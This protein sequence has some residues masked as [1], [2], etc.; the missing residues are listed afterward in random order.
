[1]VALARNHVSDVGPFC[2]GAPPSTRSD[3]PPITLNN[4]VFRKHHPLNI[5]T[6]E[7]LQ[8]VPQLLRHLSASTTGALTP[9]D[10]EGSVEYKWRLTNI[11]ATRLEHLKTQMSFRVSEGN[12]QCFYEIGVAD[13]GVQRGLE[14]GD[15]EA[16][17][18]TVQQMAKSLELECQ[19]VCERV[20]SLPGQPRL[21]CAEI[22]VSRPSLSQP[23]LRIAFCGSSDSGKSTLVSVLVNGSLDDGTGTM[24]QSVF[25]HKHEMT[26]GQ[27]SS[28][29]RRVLGFDEDGHVTNYGDTEDETKPPSSNSPSVR[30]AH[31]A[32]RCVK[33]VTLMDIAGDGRFSKSALLGITSRMPGYAFVCVAADRV[34]QDL[35]RY[36][37]L[38]VT[39]RVPCMLLVTKADLMCEFELDDVLLELSV[40]LKERFD[41]DMTSVTC[42]D[43]TLTAATTLGQF[44]QQQAIMI[45]AAISTRRSPPRDE[46]NA[47]TATTTPTVSPSLSAA[48]PR[49]TNVPVVVVSSVSGHGIAMLKRL[50]HAMPT[51]S[52]SSVACPP[53]ADPMSPTSEQ[54]AKKHAVEMLVES[55][56]HVPGVGPVLCGTVARGT[57]AVKDELCL[58]PDKRGRFQCVT[59]ESIHIN[60]SHTTS[61][62][63]GVDASL[64]VSPSASQANGGVSADSCHFL[65]EAAA[66][67]RRGLVLT[68][69]RTASACRVCADFEMEVEPLMAAGVADSSCAALQHCIAAGQEP[70][71]HCRNIRQ[72][73]RLVAVEPLHTPDDDVESVAASH[74]Q[75]IRV[76]CR[77]LFYP[78]VLAVGS[79][80]ILRW[81]H[82]VR[83]I[84]VVSA[85]RTISPTP[86]SFP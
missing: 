70:V 83:A 31:M 34:S 9:E 55:C 36:M 60:G 12:G 53:L 25:N 20:V 74:K 1:M 72:T 10:D 13:N 64:A 51:P 61:A 38:C 77:F 56:I 65:S 68:D 28:V 50:L 45:A 52:V 3:S 33:L 4:A 43:D 16:S 57:I 17:V 7:P 76:Q 42:D 30:H 48:T 63:A 32:Q 78:E 85:I 81:G 24:R 71:A 19:M 29:S 37:S 54:L 73:I 82:E 80:V 79:K 6:A 23:D 14:D 27:T 86:C 47:A 35:D 40:T 11:A 15:F 46:N 8:P 75:Y 44:A 62:V 2:D 66:W 49:Q 18:E 41:M 26:S 84:G 58:G 59:V 67:N 5:L 21:R 22:H 69:A 39:L